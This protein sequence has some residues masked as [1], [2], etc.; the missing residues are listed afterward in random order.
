ACV[1]SAPIAT[2]RPKPTPPL[3]E[4]VQEAVDPSPRQRAGPRR[5]RQ[6]FNYFDD[7]PNGSYWPV[8]SRS[9]CNPSPAASNPRH[10]AEVLAHVLDL[11][12]LQRRA[13]RKLGQL[14]HI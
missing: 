8:S 12:N 5:L 2:P 3:C 6:L 4:L 9:R 1:A 7:R 11:A 13:P 14:G 10:D